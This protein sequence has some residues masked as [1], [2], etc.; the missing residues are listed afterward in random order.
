MLK[1]IVM[2]NP[3]GNE[4]INFN[5]LN[6]EDDIIIHDSFGALV[7]IIARTKNCEYSKYPRQFKYEAVFFS[8]LRIFC[9]PDPTN[10]R[11]LC[12]HLINK[13]WKLLVN[14]LP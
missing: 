14:K 5:E 8:N 13:G 9:A 12:N 7:G 11:D 2:P 1:K 4:V 6:W 10:L 3:K